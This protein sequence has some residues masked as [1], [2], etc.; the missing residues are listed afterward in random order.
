[1]NKKKKNV[2]LIFSIIIISILVLIALSKVAIAYIGP[3]YGD[4]QSNNR[5]PTYYNCNTTLGLAWFV[6][7]HMDEYMSLPIKTSNPTL[8]NEILDPEHEQSIFT[9]RAINDDGSPF[10]AN[11]MWQYWFSVSNIESHVDIGYYTCSC[12]WHA[13]NDDKYDNKNVVPVNVIDLDATG[14]ITIYERS[15]K[16]ENGEDPDVTSRIIDLSDINV[17]KEI[18]EKINGKGTFGNNEEQMK[19]RQKEMIQKVV[20]FIYAANAVPGELLPGETE[21]GEEAG[22]NAYNSNTSIKSEPKQYIELYWKSYIRPYI[23]ADQNLNPGSKTEPDDASEPAV[24]DAIFTHTQQE[25]I[26]NGDW[27]NYDESDFGKY[28]EKASNYIGEPSLNQK[29]ANQKP[30]VEYKNGKAYIGP[31]KA[32]Y[33]GGIPSIQINGEEV[34]WV[35]KENG[36]FSGEQE[37][38]SYV[39]GKEFYAVIEESKVKDKEKIQVNFKLTYNKLKARLLLAR[40]ATL[41]GQNLMYHGGAEEEGTLETS[42]SVEQTKAITIKKQDASGST[43]KQEGIKFQVYDSSN[44]LVGTLTTKADGTTNTLRLQRDKEYTIKETYNSV[45]GYKGCTITDAKIT[46]GEGTTSVKN[47]EVKVKITKDSTISINNEPKLGNLSIHKVGEDNENLKGVEFVLWKG[48]AYLK[49]DNASVNTPIETTDSGLDI[50]KYNVTTVDS[51]SKATKFKTNSSGKIVINNLEIY[52]AKDKKYTYWLE[53][54]S[55]NNYGYEGMQMEE[56]DVSVSGG[57]KLEIRTKTK[58][59]KFDISSSTTIKIINKKKLAGLQIVKIKDG[60]EETKLE[61]VIFSISVGEKEYIQLKDS[62]GKVVTT[63]KGTIKINENNIATSTQKGEEYLL[64]YVSSESQATKFITDSKGT[65]VITN[66]RVYKEGDE[67]YKYTAHEI[68]NLNYGYGA[69]ENTQQKST[70]KELKLDEINVIKISNKK[71]L[72]DLEVIKYD[73]DNNDIFLEDVGFTLEISP[74]PSN[75]YAYIVLYDDKGEIVKTAKGTTI[76][77]SNNTA[78][79]DGKEYRVAY[80]GTA[81][82]LTESQREKVTTFVTGEDGKLTIKN[83]EVYSRETGNKNVYTL[84]EVTNT[85]YGY[86]INSVKIDTINLENGATITKEVGNKQVYTKLSGYVWLE[87]PSGKSDNYDNLY[88]ESETK[89]FDK[90][91][92]DLYKKN[93]DVLEVNEEAE[94]PVEIKLYKKDGTLIKDKPDDFDTKTGK[95]TF[96]EIV[97]DELENYEVVFEYDGFRYTTIVNGTEDNASKVIETSKE[98]ESLN[99]NFATIKDNN[100]IISSDGKTNKVEYNKDGHTST[101]SKFDFDTN[102][103]ANTTNAGYSLKAKFESIKAVAT[104]AVEK[105]DNINMGI[106][107]REQPKLAIGSDIYS[108]DVNVNQKGYTYYYNGRQNHYDNLNGDEIGVKFE[109]EN[110]KNRY[111][112]TVYSSDVEALNN[113]SATMSVMITYK[114]SLINQ[115]RTLTSVIKEIENYFDA[116]YTIEAIG[117]SYEEVNST[118]SNGK[119]N[120]TIEEETN[121]EVEVGEGVDEVEEAYKAVRIKLDEGIQLKAQEKQDI[122]IKFRV[123]DK[124]I[125]DLLSEKSTYHNATEIMSYATYY[126]ADTTKVNGKQFATEQAKEGN[127]YS[128]IDKSSQPGNIKLKLIKDA[129]QQGTTP[130]LD[131]SEFEDDTTSA[132]S[133]LLVAEEARK[134][135]GTIFEDNATNESLEK[136]EKLGNGIY[137]SGENPIAGVIVELREIN[138]D[139][140][141]GN[142]TKYSDRVTEART[143]TD[144]NGNYTFGYYDEE[145]KEY[146]GILPGRYVIQYTYNNEAYIVSTENKNLNVNDYKSTI[147]TS[148]V[149]KSAINEKDIVYNN[150]KYSSEKWYVIEETNRYS[151]AIDDIEIRKALENETVINNSTY[152]NKSYY[153]MK[154]NTPVMDIGIEF[155]AQDEAYPLVLEPVK[156]LKNVDFGI[157]ERPNVGIIVE[158]E[159]TSLEITA[160][161]G[162]SIVPKGNPSDPNTKMQY[163]KTGLDG[164]VYAEIESRLLQGAKLNLEYSITV[165]NDSQIDYLEDEYYLYG[166]VTDTSTERKIKVTKVTDYLENTMTIE[167]QQIEDEMWKKTT[168]KE[169]Y[170]NGLISDDVYSTLQKGN[171]HILLTEKFEEIERGEEG[172]IKLYATKYLASSDI[173]AE[174]NHTEVIE[175]EGGRTIEKSIPGNYD[176]NDTAKTEQDDDK[177]DLIVTPPTGTTTNYGIYVG[178]AIATFAILILGI[179]IIKKKIINKVS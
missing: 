150:V 11:G 8:K 164:K 91:L 47:G 77:N 136:N 125:R 45:Y 130:I 176:P 83:L 65:I 80:Y 72:G 173:I 155:T 103:S 12:M 78:T 140:T 62:N 84:K 162:S 88:T 24:L 13:V 169:L 126:G 152:N 87:N 20:T 21:G 178:A 179:V 39:S 73:E 82:K 68:S 174:C 37:S 35:V 122:Y 81:T 111:T 110:S 115:S 64:T 146:V 170:D 143:T 76:I 48:D 120:F 42:W 158:K 147:I 33:S 14:K 90:K 67:K 108:V 46:S 52:S 117:A 139:G 157:I 26:K 113:G 56:A 51:A 60:E 119:S 116:R 79:S 6:A 104:E 128:G 69:V 7:N 85:N 15:Q 163:V 9:H 2:I 71:A 141:I 92:I 49:L 101:I 34:K 96:T 165:K 106:V 30:I 54:I 118:K 22:G 154:S 100:E 25:E 36:T 38:S 177:V 153:D 17:A 27:T 43:L 129:S 156:E 19:K 28:L 93:K 23:V 114:I 53:E 5:N 59:I 145:N 31:L 144:E 171:Y 70:I 58:Q 74:S 41:N 132:P 55:N 166:I 61:D 172:T 121:V 148:D 133:L 127:L 63:I 102:V 66:L 40:N 99:N 89:S 161:N 138:D 18:Y 16:W 131:T 135:S 168:A 3:N 4:W 98:R 75:L 142:I 97:I 175:L 167:E 10:K 123:S 95:Y 57:N 105:I 137:D 50:T 1:M 109:Q 29:D 107:I 112:R 32:T 149:I 160:Q 94:I 124:A 44:N 159:I 151:D 86:D 134:I